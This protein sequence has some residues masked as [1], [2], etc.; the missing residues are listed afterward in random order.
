MWVDP[1]TNWVA[2]DYFNLADWQR[3]VNNGLYVYSFIGA[4]FSWEDCTLADTMALPYYDIVNKLET[5]LLNLS[6]SPNIVKVGF[7]PTTWKPRTAD[8]YV[9]NPSFED[10]NRWEQF[11]YDLHYQTNKALHQLN[12]LAAGYFT[13]GTDRL[14]QYF[15]R[16]NKR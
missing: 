4:T 11:E 7:T 14:R 9:R 12:F 10:F 16:G 8:D 3:I 5:N 13:A 15:A 1:K 6:T 2:T